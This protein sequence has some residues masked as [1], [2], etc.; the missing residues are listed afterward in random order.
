MKKMNRELKMALLVLL[1]TLQ[2][3]PMGLAASIPLLLQ[4]RTTNYGS[5]ALF[6]FTSWPFSLKLLW[7]PIVD[8]LF[9]RKFGRRK[10]WLVPAQLLIGLLMLV[11][12]QPIDAMLNASEPNIHAIT[13]IFFVLYFLCATQDIAV[14]GWAL[15]MLDDNDVDK[16]SI[17][18]SLGQSLGYFT[19]YLLF[20]AL[21]DTSVCNKYFRSVPSDEPLV[22]LGDFFVFFGIVFLV[23]TIIVAIFKREEPTREHKAEISIAGSYVKLT[24]LLSL[25]PVQLLGLFLLTC[26]LGFVCLES[27][28]ALKLQE[29]GV[30]KAEIAALGPL[31]FPVQLLVPP[32]MGRFAGR[33]LALWTKLYPIRIGLG[34]LLLCGALYAQVYLAPRAEG[35]HAPLTMME[36]VVLLVLNLTSSALSQAMFTL[37]MQFYCQ[38]SD[39]SIG[40]TYMTFLNTLTNL[41]GIWPAT[42]SMWLIGQLTDC[43]SDMDAHVCS[44]RKNRFYI[45]A[46]GTL[47]I[48]L[49][50]Y[51]YAAPWFRRL[52][53]L[54]PSTWHIAGSKR[55][56]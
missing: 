35:G 17:C 14:D 32:L 43:T 53:T 47:V 49:L 51:V 16:A 3:I 22:T 33:R 20:I 40:G 45:V 26:R 54:P 4:E 38:I 37:Q 48:G 6:S 29:F 21:N 42:S 2:G 30:P 15:T 13:A 25:R 1:Y 19:S 34:I 10:T 27:T 50:W 24:Q 52:E 55:T 8:G 9:V 7:A 11:A 23:T 18:N 12:A 41:G 39:P 46:S 31:A 5:Q 44:E 28:F 56:D 36:W